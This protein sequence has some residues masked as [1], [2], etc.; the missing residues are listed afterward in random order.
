MKQSR[1]KKSARRPVSAKVLTEAARL[2]PIILLNEVETIRRNNNG[3]WMDILYLALKVAPK[4]TKALLK[5][6]NRNDAGV[7]S[8]LRKIARS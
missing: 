6:I 2:K 1:E 3:L 8:R 7:T 5:R 4:E